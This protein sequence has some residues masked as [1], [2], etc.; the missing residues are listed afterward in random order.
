MRLATKVSAFY[1]A[2]TAALVVVLTA[3]TLLAFR[4]YS[5]T[6]ATAHA[7]TAAE[8]VRVHLTEAMLLGTIGERARFLERLRDVQNL[9][10]VY[11]MRS[12]L[13]DE[14]F[15]KTRKGEREPDPVEAAVLRTGAPHFETVET[16]TESYFRAT[17]PYIATAH[18]T[19]NCL[20]CHQVAEGSVLGAITVTIDLNILRQHAIVTV[21]AI[22]LV[23]ALFAVSL[24]WLLNRLLRPVTQT[25]D[26][27]AEVVH[28]GVEGR[29]TQRIHPRSNDETGRI[30]RE[31]NRLLDAIDRALTQINEQIARVA[32]WRQRHNNQLQAGVDAVATLA[33]I[34][35]FKQSIEEDREVAEIY[36]RILYLSRE[37]FAVPETTLLEPHNGAIRVI[38]DEGRPLTHCCPGCV[39]AIAESPELCRA[40]RTEH[41]VDGLSDP[42]VCTAQAVTPERPDWGYLCFPIRFSG[43][44]GAIVQWRLPRAAGETALVR[45]EAFERYLKEAAP[46]LESKRLMAELK[47]SALRDPLTGLRN[48]RFLEESVE[49]LIAR[50]LREQRHLTIMMIDIDY[51][52]QVNDTFGHDAGD[53]VIRFVAKLL[54][55]S[56]RSSD[57]VI[58]FGGE[59]FLVILVDTPADAAVTVAD[60]IRVKLEASAIPLPDGTTIQKTLSVGIADFPSD[61]D[62]FWR[63][64]KYADVAL[65]HAKATGRNRVVRFTPELWQENG[66]Y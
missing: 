44:V 24:L 4:S 58:R 21:M 37:R 42:T 22:V 13:V 59:E 61:S 64:V 3:V 32:G 63:A 56:V 51:F 43:A 7:Q 36:R 12:H 14:Q 28:Q 54:L 20:Q 45:A 31:V 2:A 60:K 30:A 1:L 25:A 18:G 39:A 50:T 23:I 29:F 34:A 5:L 66:K 41:L 53:A 33:A 62:A 47:E 48:R 17:I 11:V 9:R 46:V 19:P 26:E 65:Y 16:L 10:N 52:K 40:Y 8:I 15:G 35:H 6:S 38:G 57:W 55:E 27:I 49:L